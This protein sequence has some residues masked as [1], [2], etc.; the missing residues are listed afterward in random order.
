VAVYPVEFDF[1][2][3]AVPLDALL[4]PEAYLDSAVIADDPVA[5]R[6]LL[7]G[8]VAE[9]DLAFADFFFD[10]NVFSHGMVLDGMEQK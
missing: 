7:S 2:A 9:C 3:S 8:V 10:S 4:V 5:L 6:V 1:V